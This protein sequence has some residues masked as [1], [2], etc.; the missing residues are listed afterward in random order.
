MRAV[1]GEEV[2]LVTV[3]VALPEDSVAGTKTAQA[4]AASLESRSI[5]RPRSRCAFTRWLAAF[6]Q[7]TI[8]STKTSRPHIMAA[9]IA[10]PDQ[11]LDQREASLPLHAPG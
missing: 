8:R 5:R 3:G 1:L 6:P 10:A 7:A 11:R 9:A 4:P 2:D